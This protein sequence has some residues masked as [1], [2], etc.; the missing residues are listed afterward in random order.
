MT[1]DP[2]VTHEI[3]GLYPGGGAEN[4][5]V[6]LMEELDPQRRSRQSIIVLRPRGSLVDYVEDLGVPVQTLGMSG[7]AN[8]A[9][10]FRLGQAMRRTSPQVVQTWMLHSNVLGGFVTRLVSRARVSWGVHLSD[11]SRE[12]LGTKAIILTRA[13]ALC[14]WFVPSSIVACS[15]SSREAMFRLPY[16]RKRIVTIPNG[17]DTT[18]FRPDP[19]AREETR[20][21]LGLSPSTTVIGHLARNHPIKDHPTLLAAAKQVVDRDPEVRFVLA[22]DGVTRDDPK[23]KALAEPLGDKVMMLGNRDDVPR[24]LNGFDLAVSSSSGE[25]LS[26]AIG[27][28]MA[29]GL[30]VAATRTGDSAE[31]VSDTGT[32]APISDPDGLATAMLELVEMGPERRSDLGTKARARISTFYSMRGM[33]D[34]Y[35][36]LWSELGAGRKRT[37]AATPATEQE[38]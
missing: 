20:R 22:G 31:L 10:V 6:R 5:L 7:R 36:R 13:E 2:K 9:D 18:R 24:L 11:F 35:V 29:T 38:S 4:M 17:F 12:T 21:E 8:P 37:Q 28:A 23:L 32:T 19:E 16:R 34:S 33:A 1:I 14:S 25:A 15:V 3:T 27:E 30:P 26:L